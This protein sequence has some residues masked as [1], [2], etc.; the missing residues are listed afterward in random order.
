MRK[1][2]TSLFILL[3]LLAVAQTYPWEIGGAVHITSYQGD[4]HESELNL[5][6][7][8]PRA[9]VSIHLR[10]NVS[11]LVIIR[12]NALVGQLAGA[13]SSF[14]EPAWRK[15]RNI[16]FTS[17]LVEFTALGEFYP[18][19]IFRIKTDGKRRAVAPFLT[20]GVGAAYTNPKV[21][22]NDEFGNGEVDVLD[23]QFDKAAKINRFNISVPFGAGVRF[24]LSTRSTL[25]LEAVMRPTFSDYVDGVSRV[26]N[27][28]KLDWFFTGGLSFSYAFGKKGHPNA[29]A[30]NIKPAVIDGDGDGVPDASDWC[31]DKPG[32]AQTGGCP[33]TDNDGVIDLKDKC[34]DQPGESTLAGCPDADNDGVADKDD[35]CPSIA[36]LAIHGGCPDTDGDGVPDKDDACP[37]EKGRANGCPD[38][39]DDGVAD[40]NDACPD[41]YGSPEH[42]GC[43]DT[44]G[45]GVFDDEDR[46]ITKPGTV[47]AKGC[48]EIKAE[49]K[50]K[51]ESA[52]KL[53][54]FET[55]KDKLLNR[56]YPT[57]DEVAAIMKLYPEYSLKIS[58]HTDNTGDDD[59]N[60]SLSER[61]AKTCYFYL[62]SK[63]IEITR[64]S[65]A[66]Y[67]EMQPI[68]DNATAAGRALNRRVEFELYVE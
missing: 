2:T 4:L 60:W 26:G 40:K 64:M 11:N 49:D 1:L 37:L 23:A 50:A 46:C 13:D 55:G 61:R 35:A 10:R 30:S 57:L 12:L 22:W 47:A 56:S 28:N 29:V 19:G 44:D 34:P 21:D 3:P 31:P 52:V 15:V 16:S 6:Q 43:P 48:P 59:S 58:G 36:G 14:S 33:D 5:G 62:L 45:D 68:A 38:R 66:G 54:Q 9:A 17:P 7:Y 32:R 41:K 18:F 27:P 39:D 24:A 42:K 25:G 67:G 53:V 65:H 8:N 51:L 20:G 63:G